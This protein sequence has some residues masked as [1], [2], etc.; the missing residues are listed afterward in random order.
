MAGKNNGVLVVLFASLRVEVQR[1]DNDLQYSSTVLLTLHVVPLLNGPSFS[2]CYGGRSA[3]PQEEHPAEE[4]G[5]KQVVRVS[6][7][8]S[9]VAKTGRASG[10][11]AT[12]CCHQRPPQALSSAACRPHHGAYLQRC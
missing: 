10:A 3:L 4:V 6:G 8:A 5:G 1:N 11:T 2:I 7:G 9:A 12:G